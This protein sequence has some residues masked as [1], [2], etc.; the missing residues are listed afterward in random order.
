MCVILCHFGNWTITF[1]SISPPRGAVGWLKIRGRTGR[2][3]VPPMVCSS[4][5][6]KSWELNH[7]YLA[8]PQLSCRYRFF[9]DGYMHVFLSERRPALNY[10][11]Y[12]DLVC[13]AAGTWSMTWSQ[14][15]ILRE[16]IYK[17][18]LRGLLS[19]ISF[20]CLSPH[21]MIIPKKL[22]TFF[23]TVACEL[24]WC[25]CRMVTKNWEFQAAWN[26]QTD[27]YWLC[28]SASRLPAWF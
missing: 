22:L 20:C 9:V 4:P 8:I 2:T 25:A 24:Q 17:Y 6:R 3:H 15:I 11:I 16:G 1:W 19:Q 5:C 26:Y 28:T 21:G 10:G 27:Q 13:P 23:F 7:L 18:P 14:M 12:G